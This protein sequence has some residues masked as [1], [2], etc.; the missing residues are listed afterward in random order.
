[1]VLEHPWQTQSSIRPAHHGHH[2]RAS[3]DFADFR[4][5]LS[6][7]VRPSS[8]I[9]LGTPASA[10]LPHS[11]GFDD[12]NTGE[13]LGDLETYQST[14]EDMANVQLADSFKGELAAIEQWF[15]LLSEAER[16]AALYAVLQQKET[17]QVQTRFFITVLQQKARHDPMSAILS[18]A[19]YN[20]KDGMQARFNEAMDR[21]TVEGESQKARGISPSPSRENHLNI[22]RTTFGGMFPDAAAA[23]AYQRAQ[24]NNKLSNSPNRTSSILSGD[25]GAAAKHAT[26]GAWAS[27]VADYAHEPRPKSA[28]PTSWRPLMR[29]SPRANNSL[30]PVGDMSSPFMAPSGGNWASMVNTPVSSMFPSSQQQNA[31]MIGNPAS[32][33]RA[34]LASVNDRLV[35]DPV[36]RGYQQ[37]YKSDSPGPRPESH[38]PLIGTPSYIGNRSSAQPAS[39]YTPNSWNVSSSPQVTAPYTANDA[40]SFISDFY[41]D[42]NRGRSPNTSGRGILRPPEDPTDP[43]LL[44][45]IPNWLRALRLH[46][47]TDNLQDLNWQDLVNLSDD[48]LVA[49]GVTTIGARRKLLKVCQFD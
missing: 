48:Q 47:Y 36:T 3:A 18:P 1:M 24:M 17:T 16:T 8:E 29:T 44:Q 19:Q 22:N 37:A 45:D 10:G 5:P 42:D 35:L 26:A 28:D 4:S 15:R 14:L 34:G 33:K 31:E 25:R 27:P 43:T 20:D 49:R 30:D 38:N 23:I 41:S 32:T 21:L 2:I 40:S 39:S 46:K 7:R 12:I 6:S 9:Y 13:W 11:T